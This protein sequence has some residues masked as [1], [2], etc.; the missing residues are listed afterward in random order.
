MCFGQDTQSVQS[1]SNLMLRCYKSS[2]LTVCVC[3][4]GDT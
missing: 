1:I 3:V 2:K 4:L